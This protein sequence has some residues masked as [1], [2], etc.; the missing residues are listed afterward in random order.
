MAQRLLAS[1]GCREL[2]DLCKSIQMQDQLPSGFWFYKAKALEELGDIAE[3][4]EAYRAEISTVRR[5]PPDLLRACRRMLLGKLSKYS[6]SSICLR[7]N[8]V[9]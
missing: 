4:I 3:A 2:V 8:H 6:E 1:G 5:V 9:N 7:K